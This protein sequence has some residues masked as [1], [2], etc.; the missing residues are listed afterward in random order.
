[1]GIGASLAGCAANDAFD[2]HVLRMDR[3]VEAIRNSLI[4]TNI[5]RASLSAPLSF[6]AV[7]TAHGS[8]MVGGTAGIPT[9]TFGSGLTSQ[10]GQYAFGPN[11][12]TASGTTSFDVQP[13]ESKD[14]YRGLLTPL[15]LDTLHFFL[16][17]GFPRDILFY[18]SIDRLVTGHGETRRELRNDPRFPTF[19]AM[20][21]RLQGALDL[22][23]TTEIA[24]GG[25]NKTARLCFD[26]SLA[27]RPIGGARPICGSLGISGFRLTDASGR[28][29]DLEVDLR[30]TQGIFYALG[31]IIRL[32][33]GEQVILHDRSQQTPD[34]PLFRVDR[35]IAAGP[36]LAE[37]EYGGETYCIPL[38]AARN[39]A[40]SLGLLA[41]LL[42]LNTSLNDLPLT[43]TVRI[44]P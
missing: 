23:L 15:T 11:S 21:D 31:H 33:P 8:T 16:Q 24:A 17:Q 18:L 32:A 39:S 43:N 40:L 34:E 2:Q 3:S 44:T 42:A 7:P 37:S 36:C 41:Q 29:E 4:L 5:V 20:S 13:L 38:G 12:L 30:S 28:P 1:M 22:G 14:F 19:R 6:V 26:P 27:S 9:F 25:N 35:G 10:Q